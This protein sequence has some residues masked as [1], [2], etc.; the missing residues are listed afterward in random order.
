MW[1]DLSDE[2]W[3]KVEIALK[4]LILGDYAKKNNVNV[5]A[6]TQSEIATS[7]SARRSRRR[8]LQRQQIAEIEK[9]GGDAAQMTAVTTKTTNVHGDELIVTTTS[10]YEQATFGRRRTGACA[11][12]ARRT[13]TCA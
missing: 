5:S 2:Q 9:A 8:V 11:R 1:P 7:S 13:C 12:S 4:D 6:L 10:P 3:I